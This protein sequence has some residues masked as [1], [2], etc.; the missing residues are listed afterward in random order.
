M[1]TLCPAC[2]RQFRVRAR[3]LAAA[4]G[5]VQ[6]GYCGRQFNA[7][8]HLY[9]R[10]RVIPGAGA[11]APVEGGTPE[12]GFHTP[13]EGEG[14]APP[15]HGADAG[16]AWAGVP[17]TKAPASSRDQA[18]GATL[19]EGNTGGSEAREDVPGNAGAGDDRDAGGNARRDHV[20]EEARAGYPFPQELDQQT[21]PRGRALSTLLWSLGVVLLLLWGGAQAAWFYRDIVLSRYPQLLPWARDICEQFDCTLV[22]KRNIDAIKLINRDVRIHPRYEH[23]LLVNATFTNLSRYRQRFPRILFTLLDTSG[24]IIAYRQISAQEYLDS[25]VD[26]AAGMPPD[27]PIHIVFEVANRGMDA[28]S[29]EFN[30]L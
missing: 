10:P 7:L 24:E 1:V 22:R 28:V 18:P 25:S 20:L 21:A 29:F 27:S 30:F 3:Q 5:L 6:C 2:N 17:G 15:V 8:D 19:A 9:D 12:P 13:P 4:E 11:S 16:P 14:H 23:A 26:G